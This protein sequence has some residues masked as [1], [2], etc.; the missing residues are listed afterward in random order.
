MNSE[1]DQLEK[2]IGI[3]L[4]AHRGQQDKAGAPYILHPLRIMLR[5]E[6]ETEM[7]VAVLHDVVEDSRWTI[8]DLRKEGFS[9]EVLAAVDRLTHR[10]GESYEAYIAGLEGNAIARKVKIADLED[11]IDLRRRKG[12]MAVEGA[13]VEKYQR[14]WRRLTGREAGPASIHPR[15]GVGAVVIEDGKVLL[16]RRGR[17]P[18]KGFW[19]IPGGLV[20]LGETLQAAAEREILEETGL[21]VRAGQPI[22]TF[23]L[24]QHGGDGRIEFHYVIVDLAA[25]FIQ[26][27]LKAGDDALEARWIAPGDLHRLAVT[28]TTLDFLK[29]I[30]FY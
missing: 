6:N 22:Y 14:A 12:L 8:E 7:I 28:P 9:E 16:V 17:E 25:D 18:G 21:V 29:S 13:R 2:A 5:M 11:N 27:E 23:D 3:A 15:V 24:I 26:G 1:S 30:R 20:E 4:D 19:A 10:A